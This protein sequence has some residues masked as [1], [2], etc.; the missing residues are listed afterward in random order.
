MHVFFIVLYSFPLIRLWTNDRE[1]EKDRERKQ[2]WK[3]TRGSFH[4]S[5]SSGCACPQPLSLVLLLP[6]LVHHPSAK[7]VFRAV[8]LYFHLFFFSFV[9]VVACCRCCL[10]SFACFHRLTHTHIYTHYFLCW[11]FIVAINYFP[12]LFRL[13]TMRKTWQTLYL[14]AN[15]K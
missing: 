13:F 10:S 14:M 15:T 7:L 8:T 3:S 9:V 11:D 12:S 4:F 2:E 5:F 1:R 6:L